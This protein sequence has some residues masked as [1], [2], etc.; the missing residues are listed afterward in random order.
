MHGM[1]NLAAVAAAFVDIARHSFDVGAR[2]GWILQGVQ[3]GLH[4]LR[5][6]LVLI[7]TPGLIAVDLGEIS[8][9]GDEQSRRESNGHSSRGVGVAVCLSEC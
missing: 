6:L 3:S 2:F 9:R 8:N 1:M 7:F 4:Q 5:Q